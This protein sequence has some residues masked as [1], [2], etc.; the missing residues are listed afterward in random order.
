MAGSKDDW[1]RP[2]AATPARRALA[3]GTFPDPPFALTNHVAA[4]RACGVLRAY[5][6]AR[7]AYLVWQERQPAAGPGAADVTRGQAALHALKALD[8]ELHVYFSAWHATTPAAVLAVAEQRALRGNIAALRAALLAST[9][10][11]RAV[12]WL[13]TR[14][15]VCKTVGTVTQALVVVSC[16]LGLGLAGIA[17]VFA[18]G[19]IGWVL[20]AAVAAGIIVVGGPALAALVGMVAGASMGA[21]YAQTAVVEPGGAACTTWQAV[22][23]GAVFGA[24]RAFRGAAHFFARP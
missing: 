12:E 2:Q 1:C 6:S 9:P 8:A 24:R 16:L 10:A 4:A 5:A 7:H 15:D 13:E 23:L 18:A 14:R 21:G 3:A 20:A 19:P 22:R 11:L 17:A